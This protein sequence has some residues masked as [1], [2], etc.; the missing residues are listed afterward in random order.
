MKLWILERSTA[1]LLP[2]RASSGS[3]VV[4]LGVVYPCLQGRGRPAARTSAQMH[5]RR[6]APCGDS[7]IQGRAAKRRDAQDIPNSQ[8]CRRHGQW[9]VRNHG[10]FPNRLPHCNS[11]L[12]LPMKGICG[13]GLFEPINVV[14]PDGWQS[15]TSY[16][17]ENCT[18]TCQSGTIPRFEQY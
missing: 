5:W 11:N 18:Y 16:T 15:V 7:S 13:I 10:D 9:G 3:H 6:K 17:V 8:E 2:D 12:P 1:P 14:A 4:S